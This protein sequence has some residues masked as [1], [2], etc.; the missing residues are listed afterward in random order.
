M[1]LKLPVVGTQSGGTPSVVRSGETGF[2]AIPKNAES[3]LK[4]LEEATDKAFNHAESFKNL[5][6]TA[7]SLVEQFEKTQVFENIWTSYN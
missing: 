5:G 2:L 6:L 4:E 3:L 1:A 7:S